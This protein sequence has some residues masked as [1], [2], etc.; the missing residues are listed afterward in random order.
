MLDHAHRR[1]PARGSLMAHPWH[2]QHP[3]LAHSVLTHSTLKANPWGTIGHPTYS[4]CP[5]SAWLSKFL[6]S[7]TEFGQIFDLEKLWTNFGFF[8][9]L[10]PAGPPK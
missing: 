8:P 9:N 10:S 4:G 7:W 5:L 1:G 3:F 6:N 2:T